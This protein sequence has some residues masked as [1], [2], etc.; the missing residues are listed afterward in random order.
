MHHAHVH[1]SSPATIEERF[2]ALVDAL[3]DQPGVTAPGAPG[4]R[5]FGSSA[6]KVKGSIFAMVSRGHLIV[7]LPRDRVDALI[8][9]GAGGPFDAGKGTP[10]KEWLT[11]T[12][13]AEETALARE[14]LHFVA[15]GGQTRG[16]RAR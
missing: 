7:K 5:G 16:R 12:D 15:G 2:A 4:S 8:R 14:A 6:L 3:A 13:E 10:M 11:V 1:V 9:S